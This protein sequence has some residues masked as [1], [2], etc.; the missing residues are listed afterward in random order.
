MALTDNPYGDGKDASIDAY[1]WW[2]IGEE[3]YN[4]KRE[5]KPCKTA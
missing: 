5:Y 4:P 1:V 3:Q 2:Q